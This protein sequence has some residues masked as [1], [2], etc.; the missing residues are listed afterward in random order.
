MSRH[1]ELEIPARA[2]FLAVARLVVVAAASTD[3]GMGEERLEDLRIAVSEACTNAIN[4]QQGIGVEAAIRIVCD[5]GADGVS[6]DIID[7]GPGFDPDHVLVAPPAGDPRRLEFEGGLGLEIMRAL[8][9][10][11]EIRTSSEGTAVRLVVYTDAA[12]T[13]PASVAPLG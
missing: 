6:V 1:V 11:A 7:R 5:L 9:D 12:G 10:R 4:A 8:T 3:P 13:D 2:D